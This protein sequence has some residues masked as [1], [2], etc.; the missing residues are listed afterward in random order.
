MQEALLVIVLCLLFSA[1][2]SGMEIAFVSS[3][4]I[5]LELEKKKHGPVAFLMRQT[6]KNPAKFIATMLI[7][8]NVALVVYGIFMGDLIVDLIYPA[9]SATTQLPLNVLLI[10]TLISTF[11]IL[12]TAEF[13]PKVFFQLYANQLFK[14]FLIPA[15]IFFLFFSPVTTF[16]MWLSDSLFHPNSKQERGDIQVAFSKIEIGN[17]ISEQ[18]EGIDTD[19][20]V[21]SEIQLFQNALE[22]SNVKARDVMVP[23]TEIT[24]VSHKETPDQLRDLFVKS[25]YS[26]IL[27]YKE[28][29]DNIVGYIHS[30]DLFKN[31]ENIRSI[32]LPIEHIPE[33]MYV[34]DLF[35]KLTKK[36][37][38]MAVVLDEYGGTAGLITMEDIVEELFG[39]IEDEHDSQALIEE[40]LEPGKWLFS[41]RLAVDDLNEK[42][43]LNL[44]ESSHYETLGGL[45]VYY[46]EEIP[47]QGEKVQIPPYKFTMRSVSNTKIDLVE[48]NFVEP[49]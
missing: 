15:Y 12:M 28:N 31:P 13:L 42:Y 11:I 7:G 48:L 47:S 8:N 46:A 36:H 6:V 1:F 44:P 32:I 5:Y 19:E 17:F 29:L 25:G 3:N 2:F 37:K 23:R 38:S 34:K 14:L 22:F 43:D 9:L 16:V 35:D 45:I 30:F 24:A 4:K 21:D 33:S 20:E 10:Q 27:V 39:E 40:V 49:S 26:K 41:A 18:M